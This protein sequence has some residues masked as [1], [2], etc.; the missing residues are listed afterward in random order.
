MEIS[1]C[2]SIQKVSDAKRLGK[3]DIY[4]LLQLAYH[5]P[6]T[7]PGTLLGYDTNF[8]LRDFYVSVLVSVSHSC[9]FSH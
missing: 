4:D 7:K 1:Y 9:G 2:R 3:D 8:K 5:L 6:R